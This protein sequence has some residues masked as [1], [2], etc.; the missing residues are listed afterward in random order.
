[1]SFENVILSLIVFVLFIMLYRYSEKP[2]KTKNTPNKIRFMSE[3]TG[4]IFEMKVINNKITKTDFSE[5]TFLTGAKITFQIIAEAFT[6]GDL[7][8]LKSLLDSE[9]YQLFESDIKK[10]KENKHSI[11][12]S[13]ICFDSVK[14][15]NKSISKDEI[16]VQF[17]TEQINLLKNSEGT[18]LEGDELSVATVT[19]TWTFKKKGKSKWIVSA[20]K[21]GVA[22]A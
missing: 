14:I 12:F 11:D 6:K 22:H 10:R 15:L 21:S 7:S 18:V 17:I 20:T 19:D 8:I 9:L 4:E 1:M 5:E 2:T 16:T 3:K 13:L